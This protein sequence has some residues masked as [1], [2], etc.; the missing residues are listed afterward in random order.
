LEDGDYDEILEMEPLED[1][2]YDEIL[3]EKKLKVKFEEI[4]QDEPIEVEPLEN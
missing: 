4:V 2:D 1:G 3:E